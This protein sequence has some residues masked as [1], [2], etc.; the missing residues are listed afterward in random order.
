MPS[1]TAEASVMVETLA[2]VEQPASLKEGTSA[3]TRQ[4]V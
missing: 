2:S 4:P 3:S 1:A